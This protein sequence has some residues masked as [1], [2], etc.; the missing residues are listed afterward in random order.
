M[1]MSGGSSRGI[2][3]GLK[4]NAGGIPALNARETGIVVSMG[5][6]SRVATAVEDGAVLTEAATLAA[7]IFLTFFST[8]ITFFFLTSEDGWADLLGLGLIII[9][10]SD[11]AALFVPVA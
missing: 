7:S 9:T 6:T 4:T 10:G 11:S 8:T 1:T 5:V 3:G 2:T